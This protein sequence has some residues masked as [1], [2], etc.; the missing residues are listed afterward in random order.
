MA[1][2]AA[3]PDSRAI[4]FVRKPDANRVNGATASFA[5]MRANDNPPELSIR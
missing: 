3:S 5:A 2:S 1:A 4:A